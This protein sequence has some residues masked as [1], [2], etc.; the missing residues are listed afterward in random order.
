M[1]AIE[2]FGDAAVLITLG[3]SIDE[4]L[5]RRVHAL[6]RTLDELR[7]TDDRVGRPVAG[8]AG[9]MLPVDPLRLDPA[10]TADLVAPLVARIEGERPAEDVE[11]AVVELPTTYGGADGPDLEAVAARAGLSADEVVEIHAG[12]TYRV[13]FVGFLPGFAYLGPIPSAIAMPRHATPRTSVPAGSVGIAGR[14]TG[15]YP[16]ASPGGWQIIGRTSV[17]TWDARR[18]PP[19][20]LTAGRRV[21]FVPVLRR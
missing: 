11:Q 6:W 13:A 21:R 19:A 2:P 8:F 4:T 1:A 12:S 15:V 18:D 3:E 14:Q 9:V 17:A 7:E 20:L 5:I 16:F 10:A